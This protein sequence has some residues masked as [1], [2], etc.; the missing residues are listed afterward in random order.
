MPWRAPLGGLWGH[1]PLSPV[2]C[3][4]TRLA[5][6]LSPDHG[7]HSHVT[8]EIDKFGWF[9]AAGLWARR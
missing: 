6:A 4:S 5:P 9:R 3:S 2:F 7:Q 1:S 8:R